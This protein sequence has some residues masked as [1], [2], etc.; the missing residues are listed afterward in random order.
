VL[1]VSWHD[2]ARDLLNFLISYLPDMVS[3]TILPLHLSK[4]DT[5]IALRR[6]EHGFENRTIVGGGHSFGGVAT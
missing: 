2:Q 4:I 3:Q 5:N 6:Q 1:P